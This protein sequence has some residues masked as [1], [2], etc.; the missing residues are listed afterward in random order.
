MIYNMDYNALY[1]QLL[2]FA[3]ISI[4]ILYIIILSN[5]LYIGL[6]VTNA[7]LS[8]DNRSIKYG[9]VILFS[10]FTL[11]ITISSILCYPIV[12]LLSAI[13][14]PVWIGYHILKYLHK[15]K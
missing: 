9:D 1:F 12:I 10:L 8:Y 15:N 6:N 11:G 14:I 7:L 4:I 13:Y 3:A 2:P 5:Y